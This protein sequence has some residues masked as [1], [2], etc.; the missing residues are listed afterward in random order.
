MEEKDSIKE[1]FNDRFKNFE[2]DVDTSVWQNVESQIQ[3]G[4]TSSAITFSKATIWIAG[5]AAVLSVVAIG[6]FA[7]NSGTI[8]QE[9]GITE[10]SIEEV[11][12]EANTL[13]VI[14]Q[15][16]SIKVSDSIDNSSEELTQA[17]DNA[18]QIKPIVVTDNKSEIDNTST[19]ESN[20]N[21][22]KESPE[23]T[24][25]ESQT[26]TQENKVKAFTEIKPAT[27]NEIVV[28]DQSTVMANPMGGVAPL[29]VSF[30]SLAKITKVK[31]DFDDGTTSNEVAPN[32]IY[33]NEGIY[34]VT[35]IAETESGEVVMDKAI[36]EVL[37][38]TS[39][40]KKADE[41][42]ISVPNVITPNGDGANDELIITVKNIKDFSISIF[43]VNGKLVYQSN[44]PNENW[45]GTNTQGNPVGQ[46]TYYYLVNATG[47]DGNMF[48]PKGYITVR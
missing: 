24:N 32:H 9:N 11:S 2:A 45:K 5:A 39:Q 48:A 30:S 28:E 22:V 1:L 4:V 47:L 35:M 31:W 34:F 40:V 3:S 21:G 17:N 6:Y 46:G 29:K 10:V 43:S 12:P 41:S 7:T 36:V 25:L 23:T 33:E 38:P 8:D 37:K 15:E 19:T 16:N 14:E 26:Q 18:T 44:D 42:E 20:E 13:E 27:P